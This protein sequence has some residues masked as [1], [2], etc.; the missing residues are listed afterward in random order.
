MIDGAHRPGSA[1]A[2]WISRL[3]GRG[4]ALQDLVRLGRGRVGLA[5]Q[6]SGDFVS[7]SGP[8]RFRLGLLGFLHDT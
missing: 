5:A 8:R 1:G 7:G 2:G 3:N 4:Q 6:I